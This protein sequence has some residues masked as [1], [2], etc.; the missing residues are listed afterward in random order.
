MPSSRPTVTV[1]VFIPARYGSARFPGKP[2][3]ELAGKP[4]IQHVYEAVKG[5]PHVSEIQ[6]VTDDSRILKTVKE[7]GGRACLVD[8]PCRTGTDRI[9]KAAAYTECDVAV[10][11]QGDEIP[12]HPGLL[13]DLIEPF[14][15]GEAQMG[16]LKRPLHNF[17][18]VNQPSVVKVVT[19]HAGEALYFSRSPIPY[20]REGNP[21]K[22]IANYYIHLG[23]YIFRRETLLRFAELPTGVLEEAE[24]L[25]Q[26][27]ALEHGIPIKVWETQHPSLRID[28]VEDLKEASEILAN[29]ESSKFQVS[30]FRS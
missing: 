23:I 27:R 30:S 20:L 6:V 25:E 4:L 12:L 11:L 28:H 9:A 7:F 26:L 3:A 5:I 17:E 2:L 24:K 19:N 15:H 22:S 8:S 18:E 1:A 21:M 16:T 10:N 14:L 13:S 29:V